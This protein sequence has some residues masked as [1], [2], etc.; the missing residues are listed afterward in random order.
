MQQNLKTSADQ[1]GGAVAD[2]M[3]GAGIDSARGLI[4]GLQSQEAA[5]QKQMLKIA[6]QMKNAI[7]QALGIHSPSRVFH[8]IGT[9]I[10]SGLANGVDSTAGTAVSAVANLS[11]AVARAGSSPTLS[12]GRGGGAV[13]HNHVH[14]EVHGTVRSDRELRDLFQQEMLRLGGRNSTTWQ[15]YRR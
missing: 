4:R 15:P 11:N 8:E 5:I 14:V 10:T 13:V 12:G 6:E 9:F 2:S 7:K 1:T 3:Y